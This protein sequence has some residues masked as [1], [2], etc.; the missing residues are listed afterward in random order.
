MEWLDTDRSRFSFFPFFVFIMGVAIPYAFAHRFENSQPKKKLYLKI[1]R[2]T[3]ILF[4]LGLVLN[5]FPYFDLHTIRIMGVLQR[6]A[7]CYFFSSLIFLNVRTRGQAYIGTGLLILYWALMKL[8]PVPGYGAGVLTNT[9]N[10]SAYIDNYLLRGHIWLGSKFWDPEGPLSTIPAIT[11]CIIGVLTGE[12]LRSKKSNYEKIAWMYL[13]GSV[14]LVLGTI[15]DIWFPINKNLWSPPYVVFTSGMGLVFLASCYFIIDVK[16]YKKIGQPFVVFG[17][18]ALALYFLS[19]FFAVVIGL[20]HIAFARSNVSLQEFIYQT[21]CA[22]WA[23][24][25]NGSLFFA[26]LFTFFWYL[27]ML[28]FYKKKVFIKI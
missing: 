18:N 19:E 2:R 17:M 5:G 26:I 9:G 21:V 14:G 27:V 3:A 22:S 10:L 20:V 1:V 4:A 24:N 23:G 8:V 6:L 25:L 13:G 12:F 15:L 16:G 7:L 28:L 11:S